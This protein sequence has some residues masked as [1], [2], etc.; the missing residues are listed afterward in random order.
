MAPSSMWPPTAQP[1]WP[2]TPRAGASLRSLRFHSG[3]GFLSAPIAA[4]PCCTQRCQP[5]FLQQDFALLKVFHVSLSLGFLGPVLQ[6]LMWLHKDQNSL[7]PSEPAV[8][9]SHGYSRGKLLPERWDHTKL[10]RFSDFM[11]LAVCTM[12]ATFPC[13]TLQR[14]WGVL[15]SPGLAVNAAEATLET[16]SHC[17]GGPRGSLPAAIIFSAP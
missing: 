5:G 16:L 12:R 10:I 14:N 4:I 15:T 6:L 3:V 13:L 1:C 7:V 2:C 11:C 17:R 9:C 8:V